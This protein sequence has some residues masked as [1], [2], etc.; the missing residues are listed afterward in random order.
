[1]KIKIHIVLFLKLLAISPLF[2]AIGCTGFHYEKPQSVSEAKLIHRKH[3]Y[4]YREQKPDTALLVLIKHKTFQYYGRKKS[5]CIYLF[6]DDSSFI[7][8]IYV[9]AKH[10]K[11][12]VACAKPGEKIEMHIPL[13]GK[14]ERELILGLGPNFIR[15]NSEDER[16]DLSFFE[17]FFYLAFALTKKKITIKKDIPQ[18]YRWNNIHHN[19]FHRID[20]P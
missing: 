19:S 8:K 3:Q 18:Y 9:E 5:G 15:I 1:M 6:E 13:K 20:Y 14:E 10:N 11:Y 17:D 16:N 7:K 12:F 2:F 4:K